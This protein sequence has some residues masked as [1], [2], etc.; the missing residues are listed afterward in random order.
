MLN[1]YP[2]QFSFFCRLSN[3]GFG[4]V[5]FLSPLLG[6]GGAVAPSALNLVNHLFFFVGWLVGWLTRL[7]SVQL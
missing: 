6:G 1:S 5:V 7:C 2:S 3:S 4:S